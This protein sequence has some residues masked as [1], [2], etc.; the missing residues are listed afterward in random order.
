MTN[1]WNN[2]IQDLWKQELVQERHQDPRSEWNRFKNQNYFSG[3]GVLVSGWGSG[4]V[5]DQKAAAS[6]CETQTP[7]CGGGSAA[8]AL[9]VCTC[10]VS[11][12]FLHSCKGSGSVRICTIRQCV[13]EC[14]CEISAH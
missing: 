12:R 2:S 13:C 8:N 11:V 7:Q 14:V 3:K 6:G 1:Y 9:L 10:T 5:C 4:W